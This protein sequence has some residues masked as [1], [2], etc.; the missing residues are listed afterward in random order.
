MPVDRERV[1]PSAR[2]LMQSLRDLGYDVVVVSDCCHNVH[3]DLHEWTLA[4]ILPIFARVLTTD[5]VF[6]LLA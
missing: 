2:R 3:R 5:Q 1:A 4:K 6:K